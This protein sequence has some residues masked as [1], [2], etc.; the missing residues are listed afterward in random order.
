MCR[1][2]LVCKSC[3]VRVVVSA[4]NLLFPLKIGRFQREK[5]IAVSINVTARLLKYGH[6]VGGT[7][8]A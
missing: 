2:V 8:Q 4:T 7:V 3:V 6:R 5:Q 1:Y